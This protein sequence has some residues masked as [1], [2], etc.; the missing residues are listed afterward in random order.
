MS[1]R[2]RKTGKK[3][4]IKKS[5]FTRPNNFP[6]KKKIVSF[7]SSIKYKSIIKDVFNRLLYFF[8]IF[9]VYPISSTFI[10]VSLGKGNLNYLQTIIIFFAFIVNLI[11]FAKIMSL[12]TNW[13]FIIKYP[14][15]LP[16]K[17]ILLKRKFFS[18]TTTIILTFSLYNSIYDNFMIAYNHPY[19]WT[20]PLVA[21]TAI[22]FVELGNL[23]G[24]EII[25]W[26]FVLS[27]KFTSHVLKKDIKAHNATNVKNSQFIELINNKLKFF[28]SA[29]YQPTDSKIV[30]VIVLIGSII[31]AK[32]VSDQINNYFLDLT[33]F[34]FSILFFSAVLALLF[35]TYFMI[36]LNILI[37][38]K[39]KWEHDIDIRRN[40]PILLFCFFIFMNA[41]Y[42]AKYLA[43]FMFYI[44]IDAND[45]AT[46]MLSK[47][48]SPA[49]KPWLEDKFF[50]ALTT[51][52]D[53]ITFSIISSILAY[54][55]F[56][57]QT[58]KKHI[59][60]VLEEIKRIILSSN[61]PNSKSNVIEKLFSK[62]LRNQNFVKYYS[63][64]FYIYIFGIEAIFAFILFFYAKYDDM[65][66][67]ETFKI[68]VNRFIYETIIYTSLLP[69]LGAIYSQ[70][71]VYYQYPLRHFISRSNWQNFVKILLIYYPIV[72]LYPITIFINDVYRISK[73][74]GNIVPP[75][76]IQVMQSIFSVFVLGFLSIN[77]YPKIEEFLMNLYDHDFY[78]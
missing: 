68:A 47:T 61:K 16:W 45:P 22:T 70:S 19:F 33:S 28:D 34:N 58:S 71:Q 20:N 17:D 15:V 29:T 57:V 10:V 4:V 32:I 43:V 25:F 77:I 75:E 41:I 27:E 21:K 2:R 50:V 64:F 59:M 24:F 12:R 26:C 54:I 30:L 74:Y 9:V 66:G 18:L 35:S 69:V 38:K 39:F 62:Q 72:F 56:F 46:I 65:F 51:F 31:F 44:P 36:S 11:S 13:T 14:H 7:I 8:L 63:L 23:F 55:I 3:N 53:Y 6:I 40:I 76:N 37:F 49:G 42:F 73:Q 52:M 48:L 67:A 60:E 1:S 5:H 78:N